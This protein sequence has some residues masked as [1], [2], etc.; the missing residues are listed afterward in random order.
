[1]KSKSTWILLL[2]ILLLLL[3]NQGEL[4]QNKRTS[5]LLVPASVDRVI[6]GDTLDVRVGSD[7][8]RIR[9][10]GVDT[11]EIGEPG[12]QR[13]K[14]YVLDLLPKNSIVYLES[15]YNDSDIYGRLLRYV[16]LIEHPES[17]TK[18]SVNGLLLEKKLGSPLWINGDVKYEQYP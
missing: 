13:A 3:R 16:W 10:I 8:I 7:V 5:T 11:P 2:I 6:D 1:M 14:Q 9:L 18:H 4:Q 15:D 17:F 12:Y